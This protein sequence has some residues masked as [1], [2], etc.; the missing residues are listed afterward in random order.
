MACEAVIDMLRQL[1]HVLSTYSLCL[2]VSF[3]LLVTSADRVVVDNPP[4]VLHVR[5]LCT[6]AYKVLHRS[7]G[8]PGQMLD[9]V[10]P[11]VRKDPLSCLANKADVIHCTEGTCAYT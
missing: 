4:T 9:R 2:F 8:R 1:E 5:V 7:S 10:G 11:G 6:P 3:P